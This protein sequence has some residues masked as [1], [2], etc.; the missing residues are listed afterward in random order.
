MNEKYGIAV[1]YHTH[2][3]PGAIGGAIWDMWSV[4]RDLDP[5]Y[6]GLNFDVGHATRRLGPGMTDGL[7]IARRY[8]QAL[9]IKDF[10]YRVDPETG[11]LEAEWTPIG[12]GHVDLRAVFDVLAGD[13]WRGPINLHFEHHGLLGRGLGAYELPI[14][15]ADFKRFI[16]DECRYVRQTMQAAGL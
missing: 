15:L 1:A 11:K 10:A 2:S 4:M 8:I 9:A 5:R 13:G 16:A 14:P 12:E 7:R 3:A 6:V